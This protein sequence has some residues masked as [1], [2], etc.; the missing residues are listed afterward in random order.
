MARDLVDLEVFDDDIGEITA[1]GNIGRELQRR[2]A[3]VGIAQG[4]DVAQ[5]LF[6]EEDA[7]E[8][9]ADGAAAEILKDAPRATGQA[10]FDEVAPFVDLDGLQ[11]GELY[12][13]QADCHI[14]TP[15]A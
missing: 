2:S 10:M 5:G 14:K 12:L 7:R 11:A 15:P 1:G 4:F 8:M 6:A 13:T 3:G 9:K